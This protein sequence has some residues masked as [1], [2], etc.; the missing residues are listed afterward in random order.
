V[1]AQEMYNFVLAFFEFVGLWTEC[2]I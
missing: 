1:F 2:K